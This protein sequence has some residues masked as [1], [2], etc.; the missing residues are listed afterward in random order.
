MLSIHDP[1]RIEVLNLSEHYSILQQLEEEGEGTDDDKQLMN[2]LL[3]RIKQLNQLT[4][5]N[6]T[7]D[8]SN[9]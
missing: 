1:I 8:S 6:Q 4:I 9:L 5:N 7:S 2:R 3:E